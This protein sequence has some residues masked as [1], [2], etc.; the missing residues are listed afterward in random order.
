MSAW[1]ALSRP[2]FH[3]T[4][5]LPFLLGTVMAW[6]FP[7]TLR[8]D[9]L[10]W[11]CAGVVLVMLSTYYSGEYWDIV[12]DRIA[13]ERGKSRFSGGSGMVPG[14][15]VKRKQVIAAAVACLLLALLVGFIL[16]FLYG[17]GPL[18]IP[19]GLLGITGGFLYSARPVRW[20]S[21]GVGELWIALCYGWLPVVTAFYLQRGTIPAMVHVVTLPLAFSVFSV[22]LLNEFPDY[23]ADRI[24]GK[25]NLLVRFGHRSG[26]S[27][28]ILALVSAWVSF[29]SI[30]VHY[31][32]PVPVLVGIPF[33]A[34][35]AVIIDTV[36]KSPWEDR[37]KV[38]RLCGANILVN[39]G[40]TFSLI[41]GFLLW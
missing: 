7:G 17:C 40:I 13:G 36:M 11:G 30:A 15:Q 6:S 29:F 32:F 5:L 26:E 24:A 38:E 25:T 1:W 33:L 8:W 10:L 23:D 31:G 12:E 27:M 2:P 4:G 35:S 34:V 20:V 16:T 19:L 41:A 21:R 39:M 28:F 3:L 14:G 22:I 9:I 18:T 37:K